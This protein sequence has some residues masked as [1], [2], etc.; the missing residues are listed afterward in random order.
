MIGKRLKSADSSYKHSHKKSAKSFAKELD[1]SMMNSSNKKAFAS[2]GA[3]VVLLIALLFTAC[4]QAAKPPEPEQPAPAPKH[5]ITF[6]V[7]GANGTLTAKVDGGE[8]ASGKEVEQ[9][10]IITFTATPDANHKVKGWTLDGATIAEAGTSAEYKLTVTKACTVSVS[11]TKK[12]YAVTFSVDSTGGTLKAEGDGIAQPAT[13]PITVEHGKAVTFTATANDGYRL[14]GWTLDGNAVNGTAETY[15]HTV[16]QPATITV[17]FELIPQ[18]IL[19]LDAGKKDI[20][21]KAKTADGSAIEVEGCNETTLASGT[22]T[23][24]NATGTVVV[25][26]GKITELACPHNQLT[27]LNV[28]GLTAL[29]KLDCQDNQLPKLNVQG[30]T[31]LQELHCNKNQL[32]ELNVQGLTTL[33]KL[34]CSYNK[35]LSELN[36][37]GLTALQELNCSVNKL[38]ALSVQGLTALQ[39]L[40]CSINK[41]PELNVQD[42]AS[43]KELDCLGNNLNAQ[44]MTKLLN[45]LPTREASDG[46]KAILYAEMASITEGNCKDFTQSEDLKKAVE[47]AKSRSWKL[48]KLNASGDPEGI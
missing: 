31:S 38:T 17:N 44:A 48:H 25:L 5:A 12:T 3:A 18:A 14:K 8:I 16:T 21:V 19:T 1:T 47:G 22:E 36:V 24:L 39:E 32:P 26:K 13:S 46:A 20:K 37:Q 9:G 33:Q 10:K 7:E 42:C 2:L 4:P 41:L 15:T 43:L 30:L 34:D 40:D 6:S 45:A 35:Q 11:F 28:Q 23:T 27:A 29:Q